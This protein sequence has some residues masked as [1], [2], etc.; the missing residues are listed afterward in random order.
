MIVTKIVQCPR[1][2]TPPNNISEAIVGRV[3][4]V[5]KYLGLDEDHVRLKYSHSGIQIYKDIWRVVVS[6][7]AS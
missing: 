4:G 2:K 1:K 6:P 7:P 5:N 3:S